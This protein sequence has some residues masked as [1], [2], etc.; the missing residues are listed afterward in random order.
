MGKDQSGQAGQEQRRAGRSPLGTV[1]KIVSGRANRGRPKRQPT[2]EE[3]SEAR[4][5]RFALQGTA[6]G[7]LPGE[8]VARCLRSQVPTA[9]SVDVQYVSET[10]SSHYCN[11]QVCSSVWHCPMCAA[12]ISERR[13][14]ELQTLI[15]KHVAAGGSVYMATYTIRHGRFDDLADLLHRF[16]AARR[17]MRQG[18]RGQAL[19]SDFGVIGTV[20]V[21]EVTWSV[22]NGWHPHTHELIFSMGEID[23]T[24]YEKVVR[25]AWSDAAAANGL[26]MNEHGFK[27][28]RTYG[29]VADYIAKFGHEPATDRPWGTETEMVKGHLKQ[30]REGRGEKHY[31]PFALL[32]SIHEGADDLADKFI[33][34]ARCFKGRKQLT[35]S[36]GLKAFYA[37]EEKTDEEV[38]Q[39]HE[40][41]AVT[42]VELFPE[43]WEQVLGN[44]IRGELLESARSGRPGEVINF[45]SQFGI[46]LYPDQVKRFEGWQVMTPEGLGRV[47]TVSYCDIFNRW[48]CSVYLDEA[49]E[50]TVWRAFDLVE[51]SMDVL[52]TENAS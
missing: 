24:G 20:S 1:A 14:I 50:G 16:L 37:E 28:D 45:L 30:G 32:R 41:E 8:R 25:L 11:L 9:Q 23:I 46:T 18:R 19:R 35:Y 44:D 2:P 36:P 15:S 31:T 4:V 6:A 26:E 34:Y 40:H 27:L 3:Q 5:L 21:L 10:H 12:K 47:S 48:R 42:L 43:Q 33:E 38:M 17:K 7:L 13:R 49:K 29:A 39:E 22:E 52:V 51:V